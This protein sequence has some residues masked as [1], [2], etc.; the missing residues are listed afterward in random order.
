MAILTICTFATGPTV[1]CEY[2]LFGVIAPVT[3]EL[4]LEILK[5]V[6]LLNLF[7]TEAVII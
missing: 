7:V 1:L 6:K 4:L 2:V 5:I 3:F